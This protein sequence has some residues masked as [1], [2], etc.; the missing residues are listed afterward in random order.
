MT[1]GNGNGESFVG[2]GI[3]VVAGAKGHLVQS[4]TS[5][6]S[7]IKELVDNSTDGKASKIWV[8]IEKGRL[9]VYDNGRGM[10][11]WVHPD[12]EKD[13]QA[14]RELAGDQNADINSLTDLAK[15]FHRLTRASLQAMMEST[16][17]S[18]K[19]VEK[20]ELSEEEQALIKGV[21]G[22]GGTLTPRSIANQMTIHSRPTNKVALDYW[23][24]RGITKYPYNPMATLFTYSTK[25]YDQGKTDYQIKL[26]LRTFTDPFG[27]PIES[28]THVEVFELFDG[29]EKQ[30]KP[31]QIVDQLRRDY[32]E[33]LRAGRFKLYVIDRTDT[34]EKVIEVRPVTF[35]GKKIF[36]QTIRVSKRLIFTPEIYYNPTNT[37][38]QSISVVR[39]EKHACTLRE[40]INA[41][42]LLDI[43]PWNTGL[44][45]GVI[46]FPETAGVRWDLN[47]SIPAPSAILD[48]WVDALTKLALILN[49]EI[50]E[51]ESK[52]R[53]ANIDNIGEVASQAL[54][55]AL[56]ELDM[57]VEAPKGDV[58]RGKPKKEKDGDP[59]PPTPRPP[60]AKP[61]R[62]TAKVFNEH[63]YGTGQVTVKLYRSVHTKVEE[64]A[65]HFVESQVSGPKGYCLFDATEPGNYLMKVVLPR[66]CQIMGNDSNYF[67]IGGKR[68]GKQCLFQIYT[69]VEAP[70]ETKNVRITILYD[71]WTPIEE[72]YRAPEISVGLI[73]I[74]RNGID[75]AAASLEGN[76]PQIAALL[77]SY[78]SSAMAEIRY[79]DSPYAEIEYQRQRLFAAMF[80]WVNTI[81]DEK[82]RQERAQ[83]RTKG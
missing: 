69:G 21:R 78:A 63:G 56:E 47:K 64:K 65:A 50:E 57:E 40:F 37:R 38:D 18:F 8:V 14:F 17:F 11:P 42:G 12:D 54:M 26:G 5:V 55:Q 36:H 68:L 16:G 30:L 82:R 48:D 31:S 33:G 22:I 1:D 58:G 61:T 75:F 9:H 59:K 41:T 44:L 45:M 23:P 15:G 29:V 32:A 62:I 60:K 49:K 6:I 28:G 39:S 74:N 77:C 43:S 3:I 76:Q 67:V 27:T 72:L 51:I 52:K 10:V 2:Q 46:P 80:K 70:P 25:E 7:V 83:K 71:S 34:P 79:K 53:T 73:E 35:K 19:N 4:G 81:Q 66:G 24:A 13:F 20:T